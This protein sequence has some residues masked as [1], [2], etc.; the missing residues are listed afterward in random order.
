M[1]DFNSLFGG[2]GSFVGGQAQAAG[3]GL[4]KDALF[5]AA[6]T[7]KLSGDI[8]TNLISRNM[9]RLRGEATANVGANGLR[10]SGSALDVIRSNTQQGFLTRAINVLNTNAE[11]T[12][13]FAQAKQA[14]KSEDAANV[15]SIGGLIGG[16][17]GFF[18][19][20]DL[21][22]NVVFIGRRGDGIGSY[23]FNYRG[24]KA[25]YSGVLASEIEVL[26]PDAIIMD[27]GY[28]RVNYDALGISFEKVIDA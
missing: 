21:K 24:S 3:Y 19:D 14:G 9:K 23:E 8:K 28:R 25:R 27:N 2:I 13:L 15:G 6:D 16:V 10:L 18:S 12:S 4:S 5:E 7:A 1:F 22:E 11:Y 26:R 17:L 20:D